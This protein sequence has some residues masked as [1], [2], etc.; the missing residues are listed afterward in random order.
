MGG[1]TPFPRAVRPY[2]ADTAFTMGISFPSRC[3][4][5]VTSL[6]PT[7]LPPMKTLG[8]VRWLVSCARAD[9]ISAPSA[10]GGAADTEEEEDTDVR[11]SDAGRDAW[12]RARRRQWGTG[13]Q[14]PRPVA[15]R[16]PHSQPGE[17]A[18]TTSSSTSLTGTF[19]WEKRPLTAAQCLWCADRRAR[20]QA[21]CQARCCSD[22]G[23]SPAHSGQHTHGQ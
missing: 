4:P 22:G 10:V 1:L 13:Q 12:A 18:P 16:V 2:S 8:T 3:R 21:V 11:E 17:D 14:C 7:C 9:C 20:H 5:W 15:L 23:V 19:S 6:P